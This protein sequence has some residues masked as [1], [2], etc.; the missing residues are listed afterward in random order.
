M[1]HYDTRT[2]A[3]LREHKG[4]CRPDGTPLLTQEQRLSQQKRTT[5]PLD[6][7]RIFTWR[8]AM[9]AEER[10]RFLRVAGALLKNLGYEA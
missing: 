4:C 1:L 6:P 10:G 8:R 3:R 2:P 7:S 9:S 5:E